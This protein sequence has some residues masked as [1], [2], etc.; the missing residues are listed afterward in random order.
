MRAAPEFDLTLPTGGG[1]PDGDQGVTQSAQ[2]SVTWPSARSSP[3]W[4]FPALWLLPCRFPFC[5]RRPDTRLVQPLGLI[6]LAVGVAALLWCVRD[7]Y[8]SG[9]GHSRLGR[10]RP[11][12]SLSVWHRRLAQPDVCRCHDDA[13]RLGAVVRLAVPPG[14][15]AGGAR[16]VPVANRAWRGTESSSSGTTGRNTGS[17]FAGGCRLEAPATG[18]AFGR[19][20]RALL[21]IRALR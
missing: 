13:R 18:F 15:R 10:R 1:D 21:V 9:R 2:Q 19:P 3:S 8:V 11:G 17:R 16:S 6:L 4:L 14:L 7:F 5:W 20:V 12:W